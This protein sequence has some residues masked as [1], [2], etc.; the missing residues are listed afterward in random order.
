MDASKIISFFNLVF[1]FGVTGF[2]Y[3]MYFLAESVE[4]EERRKKRMRIRHMV[5]FLQRPFRLARNRPDPLLHLCFF[6]TRRMV[7]A[8]TFVFLQD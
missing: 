4:D 2:F 7:L 3:F 6:L 5:R 1:L 8:M